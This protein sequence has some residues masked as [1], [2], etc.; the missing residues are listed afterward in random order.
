M[1][2]HIGSQIMDPESFRAAVRVAG[3]F[4]EVAR[5]DIGGGLGVDYVAEDAAPS[6]EDYLDAVTATAAAYLPPTAQLLIEP[7]RSLVAPAGISLYR[8]TT[9]KR[10]D[11]T[12][13]AVDGGMSDLIDV[14][15]TG[16][17]FDAIIPTRMHDPRGTE[18]DVVGR[19]CES[20]DLLVP[21]ARLQDPV[22]GD[23]LAIPTT[24]AYGYTLANNYNG[25]LK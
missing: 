24:G 12:F 25:A 11:R 9:V 21:S 2:V 15:L 10:N 14:A 19:Q 4:G 7:G 13:V 18:A 22:R 16:Q 6:I 5:Y 1:H 23:L 3:E 20:G 17:P 8:V